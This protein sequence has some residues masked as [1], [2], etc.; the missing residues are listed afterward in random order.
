MAVSLV[1]MLHRTVLAFGPR[2]PALTR[3]RL[4]QP[5]D[6]ILVGDAL[7]QAVHAVCEQALH[8]VLVAQLGQIKENPLLHL[9]AICVQVLEEGLEGCAGGAMNGDLGAVA[10]TEPGA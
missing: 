10:L 2:V 3:V 6:R 4:Y 7:N 9:H 5:H 1:W 8:Q